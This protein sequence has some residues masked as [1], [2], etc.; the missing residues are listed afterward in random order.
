MPSTMHKAIRWSA[1]D[2]FLEWKEYGDWRI[3]QARSKAESTNT[4]SK[5]PPSTPVQ[6]QPLE[7]VVHGSHSWAIF[8]S[9][10]NSF[11]AHFCVFGRETNKRE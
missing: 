1:A 3:V 8:S 7:Y 11:S 9:F 4:T 5:Q 2:L 6:N 10:S